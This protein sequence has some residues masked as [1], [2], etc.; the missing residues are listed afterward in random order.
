MGLY[1]IFLSCSIGIAL[2]TREIYGRLIVTGITVMFATQ[3]LINVA[4]TV[5]LAPI[6]GLPLP[7]I[8]YGGSSLISS[9]IALSFVFNVRL[10]TRVSLAGDEFNEKY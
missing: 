5:G 9:F 2:R 7:F 10:R 1:L 3:I 6:T 4:M 8:S